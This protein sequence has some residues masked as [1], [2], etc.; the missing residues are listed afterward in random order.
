MPTLLRR[1]PCCGDERAFDTPPCTD[2]HGTECAELACRDCGTA[3]L[4]GPVTPPLPRPAAP[5]RAAA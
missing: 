4:L 1:C 5:L 3:L 2:G